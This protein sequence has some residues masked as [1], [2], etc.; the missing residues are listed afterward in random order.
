MCSCSR[1]ICISSTQAKT[2]AIRVSFMSLLSLEEGRR[3]GVV[4]GWKQAE[5]GGGGGEVRKLHIVYF[6]SRNGKSEQPHLIRVHD[7]SS[8]GVYLRDVKLWLSE[9]RGGDMPES[10]VWSYKRKY[11][12]G[13][14][15]QDLMDDDLITPISDNEYMLKGSSSL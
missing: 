7:L 6:L 8:G 10:F 15:W 2:K 13:Y 14:V 11:R 12:A 5:E 4:K 1:G 9:L 3:K